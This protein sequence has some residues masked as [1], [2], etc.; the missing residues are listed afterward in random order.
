MGHSLLFLTEGFETSSTTLAFALYEVERD[1]ID[2]E[3][4]DYLKISLFSQIASNLEIQKRLQ[5]LL[6]EAVKPNNGEITDEILSK[7]TY[8][9]QI[10]YGIHNTYKLVTY[11]HTFIVN[12]CFFF[13]FRNTKVTQSSIFVG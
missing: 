5:N 6:D 9:E 1:Q 2:Y 10:I 4:A 7:I 8:L 3:I 11:L 12:K 13:S